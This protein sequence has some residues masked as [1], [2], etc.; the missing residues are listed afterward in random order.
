MK[1]MSGQAS[2]KVGAVE[3]P[4]TTMTRRMA[5]AVKSDLKPAQMAS[6][7]TMSRRP[8]GALR[9]PSQVRCGPIRE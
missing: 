7:S 6:A 1:S 9:M 4:S 5:V 8:M 3:M 2:S